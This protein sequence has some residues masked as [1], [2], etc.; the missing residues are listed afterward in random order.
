MT[1]TVKKAMEIMR[2]TLNPYNNN[3]PATRDAYIEVWNA[4]H[5]LLAVGAL[6]P[7]EWEMIW[8]QDQQMFNN[9]E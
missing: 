2:T 8:K 3:E 4:L 6:T 9:A 5:T 1:Q 7:D